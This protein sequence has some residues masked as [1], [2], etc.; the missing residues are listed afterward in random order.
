MAQSVGETEARAP[1]GKRPKTRVIGQKIADI[2]ALA[3]GRELTNVIF[4]AAICRDDVFG[5]SRQSDRLV[6]S[7]IERQAFSFLCDR[8]IKKRLRGIV[9]IKQVATLV[10]AP[11]LER[12]AP[13]N[14]AHPNPEKGLTRILDA[15]PWS[16]DIRQPQRAA[17]DRVNVVIH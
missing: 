12:L 14:S 17:L 9:D 5:E 15:H 16:V 7:H 10:S 4:S 1:A 3:L 8:G 13:D 11:N 2:D 6:A